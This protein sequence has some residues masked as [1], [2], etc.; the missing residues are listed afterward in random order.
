MRGLYRSLV[1]CVSGAVVVAL[2]FLLGV[3]LVGGLQ[4]N[5]D[6]LD[7]D[8]VSG[9]ATLIGALAAVGALAGVAYGVEQLRQA[10]RTERL[11]L[12]PYLRVDVGFSELWARHKGFTPPPCRHV[13]EPEDFGDQVDVSGLAALLP[14]FGDPA[15]TLTLWVTNHQTAPLGVAYGIEVGLFVAW[16]DGKEMQVV[17]VR[18]EFTY[19]Q[20][21]Q[22]TAIRLGRVKTSVN[23]LVVHVFA[24]SY[25]GMFLDQHLKNRHG[26]LS[27]YYDS[28]G[29]G[30]Q[31][32][33]SYGLGELS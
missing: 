23:N 14:A 15:M 5:G 31:N 13:F 7:W 4:T 25:R 8:A 22:T 27:L 18:V 2:G 30:V 6:Y 28:K 3:W 21:G 1:I 12:A 26:S 9:V 32:D 10:R 16:Q 24:V 19:V 17:E 33:R 20:P 29:G 11:S